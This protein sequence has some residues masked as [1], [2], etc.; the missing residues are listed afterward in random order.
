[1]PS[2]SHSRRQRSHEK[3]ANP[4]MQSRNE[5]VQPPPQAPTELGATFG[6][7]TDSS[8]PLFT[9]GIVSLIKKIFRREKM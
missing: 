1:M 4:K 7:G 6:Y 8:F 3:R 9:S 5:K 2:H